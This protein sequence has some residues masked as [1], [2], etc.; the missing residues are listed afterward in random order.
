MIDTRAAAWDSTACV[1]YHGPGTSPDGY[2]TW[3]PAEDLFAAPSLAASPAVLVM[4]ASL[5]SRVD[6]LAHLPRQVV[7]VAAD[8]A[9]AATLGARADLSIEGLPAGNIR[10]RLLRV[11]CA[12]AG[13]RLAAMNW[14]R[15]LV[16][17][18]RDVH[19]LKRI[20]IALMQEK[21][22]HA[23]L[24]QILDRGKALTESDGASLLLVES[25]VDNP[26]PMLHAALVKFDSLPHLPALK[27][28]R[29]YPVD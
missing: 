28:P 23:L 8:P 16:C 13:A 11:A 1:I 17:A 9:I 18:H 15:Q 27:E 6:A 4:D 3:R 14:R 2:A 7:I 21:D 22:Q 26:P 24:H 10:D 12:L 19:E 29:G 5:L 20:G 25:D